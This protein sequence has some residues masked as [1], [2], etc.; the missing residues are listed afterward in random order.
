MFTKMKMILFVVLF[1]A[2]F[3]S[4]SGRSVRLP[5]LRNHVSTKRR[6]TTRTTTGFPALRYDR[7]EM[8]RLDAERKA[9]SKRRSEIVVSVTVIIIVAIGLV[10]GC[11]W[12]YK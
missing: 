4:A 7:V 8:E 9:A 2:S 6:R 5:L 3:L 12:F 10:V 1:V 11:C